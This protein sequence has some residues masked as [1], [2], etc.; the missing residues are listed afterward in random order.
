MAKLRSKITAIGDLSHPEKLE[1]LELLRTV[2]DHVNSSSF[3]CD[4]NSKDEVC[5]IQNDSCEIVGFSTLKYLSLKFDKV[6]YPLIFSG[7]TIIHPHYWG[8]LELPIVWGEHLLSKFHSSSP[9]PYWLLISKGIRTYKFLPAF[10]RNYYP[11]SKSPT[12]LLEQEIMHQAGS[13]LFPNQY[14]SSSGL[15][16]PNNS[17]YYL[18]KEYAQVQ[19][20]VPA[21][22]HIDFF[23]SLNPRF[24]QGAELLCIAQ[25]SPQN[26]RQTI[27]RLI[28]KRKAKDYV[29]S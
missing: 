2:F 21:R 19:A 20:G 28:A 8:T 16:Q 22:P 12:P 14:D 15:V 1:M 24:Y 10:F 11:C 6:S 17:S 18:K 3:F 23:Y 9:P 4:L 5:L 29:I 25:M 26:L 13:L 7:D 27:L